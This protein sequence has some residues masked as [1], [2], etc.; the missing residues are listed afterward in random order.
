MNPYR[1]RAAEERD[2]P[3]IAALILELA[4]FERLAH[5]VQATPDKLVKR[6]NVAEMIALLL[7]DRA[8]NVNGQLIAMTA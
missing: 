1:L 4:E 3:R 6:E 5:M 8:S 2:L 7:S